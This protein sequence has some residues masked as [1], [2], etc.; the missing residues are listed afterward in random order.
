MSLIAPSPSQLPPCVPPPPPPS[1]RLDYLG[2][3]GLICGSTM[4]LLY[5]CFQCDP[6]LCY[7]YMGLEAFFGCLAA[8]G[9]AS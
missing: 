3:T 1:H 2:I 6:E 5:F 9:A 7:F 4:A 8:W